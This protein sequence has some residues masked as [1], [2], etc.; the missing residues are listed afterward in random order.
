MNPMIVVENVDGTVT[1]AE[2]MELL[3]GFGTVVSVQPAKE[4]TPG[5]GTRIAF[6]SVQSAKHG[7][8][9]IAALDGQTRWGHVL[10]IKAMKSRSGEAGP[11]SI[12]IRSNQKLN[13]GDG[14][15]SSHAW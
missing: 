4:E 12:G 2:L 6:V 3:N 5:T 13:K 9:I 11:G 8:A 1:A 10:K 14:R 15:A 7:K